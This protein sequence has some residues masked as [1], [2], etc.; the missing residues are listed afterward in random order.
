VPNVVLGLLDHLS[1][2]YN[3][4]VSGSDIF[5][6]IASVAAHSGYVRRFADELETPGLRIPLTA[7]PELFR[8][9]VATGQQ[10][11]WLHTFGERFSDDSAGRPAGP[12]RLPPSRR[13]LIITPIASRA[14]TMPESMEYD[15]ALEQLR[16]GQ[17]I[18]APVPSAVWEYEVS[19]MHV[20]RKWF[21]YRK[22]EPEGRRSSPLDDVRVTVWG[23]AWTTELLDLLNIIGCLVELE[24]TQA[25]FLDRILEGPL[26][27][28][29]DLTEAGVFPVSEDRRPKPGGGR[30][31]V[32]QLGLE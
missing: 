30:I 5:P 29:A 4:E 26:V 23:S 18:V 31:R 11:L 8:E 24:P 2:L 12:P 3:M 22:R 13:P 7:D 20:V 6:Y 9:S 14:E 27:T 21:S 17:G 15:P 16:V 32:G 10:V 25:E 1:S 28:S 19:G